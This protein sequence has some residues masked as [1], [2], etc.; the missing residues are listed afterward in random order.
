MR[1]VKGPFLGMF[2]LV[3]TAILAV[4]ILRHEITV[5]QGAIRLSVVLAVLV[6]VERAVL[7]IVRM[8]IGTPQG[9]DHLG[10]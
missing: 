1:V 3:A 10:S 7:P 9:H 5:G 2:G 6:V 8:L 4:M